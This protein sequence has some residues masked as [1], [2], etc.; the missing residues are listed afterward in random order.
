[1]VSGGPTARVAPSATIEQEA[2]LA[3][4][5][6][7]GG[8]WV[9]LSTWWVIGFG[10]AVN[11]VLTRLLAPEAFG[12]FS[13]AMFFAQVLR[14][15]P[16]LGLGY[17]YGQYP[18]SDGQTLGTFV[19]IDLGAAAAGLALV[20]AAAPVLLS[21]GYD[22]LTVRA[23][24]LLGAS[25]AVESVTATG[26]ALLEKELRF[27]QV[28]VI[29]AVGFPLSYAPAVWLA[30][31]GGGVWSLVAQNT[32]Y[33]VLC[34]I[35]VTAVLVAA[36]SRL[37]RDGWR[38][39]GGLARHLLRFGAGVG[40]G[41][42]GV[43]LL[44]QL[45]NLLVGSLMG[46]AVLGYYDRA[47]RTAQWPGTL[48]NGL[49]ARTGFYTYARLQDD[50]ARLDRALRMMVW[51]IAALALPVALAVFAA[52]PD[53]LVLLYGE[54]WLPSAP[55]LRLLALAAGVRPLVD[56]ANTL[57]AAVGKPWLAARLNG[58]QVGVL[59]LAGLPLVWRF[60]AVG[61]CLAVTLAASVGLFLVLRH[62]SA[63]A[64]GAAGE[65]TVPAL[66]AAVA[67]VGA[68]AVGVAPQVVALGVA[69]RVGLKAGCAVA[70]FALALVAA[71]P[72]QTRERLAYVWRLA[73]AERG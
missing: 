13:L 18:C 8:I 52:A 38:F 21:V 39:S 23:A 73:R 67:L 3:Y 37:R 70:L 19:T 61:A 55:Y 16:R 57:F 15:Q 66:A 63:V 68:L 31:R 49:I 36:R 34:L 35:G 72:R 17:A 51:L 28:S 54:R 62:L 32:T 26:I 11:I 7:R 2:P 58:I 5:A 10:F 40:L 14:V 48:L 12:V 56:N 45:D 6:V 20:A 71:R 65:L 33:S 46:V 27:G 53:L 69:L 64:P 50:A 9:T 60:G 41:L 24:L 59:A 44:T 1:M 30:L 25:V 22:A 43:T 42:L 29:Q 47:Y 4:R